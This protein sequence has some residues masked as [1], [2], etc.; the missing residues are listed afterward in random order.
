MLRCIAITAATD[1]ADELDVLAA[2]DIVAVVAPSQAEEVVAPGPYDALLVGE[3]EQCSDEVLGFVNRERS[4]GKHVLRLDEVVETH[5]GRVPV[6]RRP[7]FWGP[8]TTNQPSRGSAA[9]KR[10]FDI[11][12]SLVLLPFALAICLP[13]LAWI[14]LDSPG[15]PVFRQTRIGRG[16]RPFTIVKLRTMR[17]TASSTADETSSDRLRR[18]TRAGRFLRRWRIDELPQLWNVL[19]GDLSFV[20]PRPER[21]DLVPG[22][23]DRIPFYAMRHSVPPGLTGWAQ[24][25]QGHVNDVDGTALKLEYDLYYLK[26]NSLWLDV[27][28]LVRSIRTIATGF[29]AA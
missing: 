7:G 14:R 6:V 19:R 22:Y 20:G 3:G 27:R 10:L 5:T 1:I 18:V 26:Y 23:E 28:I 24:V 9:V 16:G 29:G 11:V 8:P 15:A 17:P 13:A 12:G 4:S 21:L 25:N 2:I